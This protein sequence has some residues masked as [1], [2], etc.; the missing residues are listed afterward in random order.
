MP[1]GLDLSPFRDSF[2]AAGNN[3]Q[4]KEE[5]LAPAI[6][7]CAELL[8][9]LTDAQGYV[10]S[11]T[12]RSGFDSITSGGQVASG[13]SDRADSDQG[14][15]FKQAIDEHITT[16]QALKAGL[17]KAG[18]QYLTAEDLNT[19]NNNAAGRGLPEAKSTTPQV[20][21]PDSTPPETPRQYAEEQ[22]KVTYP[23]S[24][25]P[26]YTPNNMGG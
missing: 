26:S 7:A 1:Q 24:Q 14:G 9:V 10:H 4:F 8:Q 22:F 16:V 17:E 2:T 20:P 23:G 25:P 11:L 21:A 5:A 18:R 3:L 19:I 15:S 13:L 6:T 12:F